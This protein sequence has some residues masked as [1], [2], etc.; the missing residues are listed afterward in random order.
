MTRHISQAIVL[1]D[2]HAQ[3]GIAKHLPKLHALAQAGRCK[4]DVSEDVSPQQYALTLRITGAIATDQHLVVVLCTLLR[5]GP[6]A[7]VYW[8]GATTAVTSTDF[9]NHFAECLPPAPVKPIRVRVTTRHRKIAQNARHRT[10]IHDLRQVFGPQASTTP[11]TRAIPG[12]TWAVRL[13]AGL[14]GL[15]I[16]LNDGGFLLDLLMQ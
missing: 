9:L 16:M 2:T 12:S 14:S 8:K 1:F 7:R 13:A 15:V 3:P 5:H 11:P 10:E 4:L 6:A